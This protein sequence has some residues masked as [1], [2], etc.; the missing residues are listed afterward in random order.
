[1]KNCIIIAG[2]NGEIGREFIK[3]FLP[4]NEVIAI[5]RNKSIE[6]THPHL[7]SLLIDL[8]DPSQV[9]VAFADFNPAKYDRII[10]IHSI[11][12]DKFENT[13]YP[14]IESAPTMDP[15]VYSS[16]VSTYKFLA[17]LL[18]KR[19]GQARKISPVS[20][21][22]V[23]IGSIADKYGLLVLTSFTE[24][25]NIVRGYIRDAVVRQPWIS[26][27]V[28]N[29]SSTI[30]KSATLVR[31]YADT[32]YWLTPKEVSDGSYEHILSSLDGYHEIEV[33]KK[34]PNFDENYYSD[35]EAVFKRWAKYAWNT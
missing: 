29:I 19:V 30:T 26:G 7:T 10:F 14:K 21:K 25:K 27:L 9:E 16:N 32:T 2:A 13:Q 23:M 5:S 20:L 24:S 33:Y 1:M 8:T 22:L 18:I 3:R 12:R 35:D 15:D 6:F 11:G 17:R 28:V 4:E 34:D 31:P